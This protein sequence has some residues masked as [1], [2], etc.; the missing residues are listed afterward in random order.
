MF[1]LNIEQKLILFSHVLGKKCILP[2]SCY[3]VQAY[4]SRL[5][6]KNCENENSNE[7]IDISLDIK[8][9]VKNFTI[10]QN[11]EKS[12]VEI[13]GISS[14]GYF[15]YKIM[16]DDNK[17]N[18]TLFS[19]PKK[20]I[21]ISINGKNEKAYKKLDV[22]TFPIKIFKENVFFEKLFLGMNKNLNME[23]ISYREDL[24]EILPI[25][26]KLSQEVPEV[27]KKI[28]GT[29]NLLKDCKE[30]VENKKDIKMPFIKAYKACFY[31]IFVPR[32]I[33][34]Q[35][36]GIYDKEEKIPSDSSSLVILTYAKHIIRSMFFEKTDNTLKILPFLFKEFHSGRFLNIDCEDI[37]S[38]D[39]E[40]SKKLI[41]RMVLRAKKDTSIKLLLQPSVKNFRVRK[42]NGDRG[43]LFLKN[44]EIFIKENNVYY[45]D[46]FKK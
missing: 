3:C 8:G 39:I 9:P 15:R 21:N 23:K 19:I 37:G 22:L 4:V 18:L 24:K 16:V 11:L 17:I 29:A 33:D 45:F 31:D 38:L 27:G 41:R 10:S 5:V 12:F 7:E 6:I 32:L 30:A 36:Q 2:K 26:F 28:I 40:W 46:R 20:S 14:E 43:K 34:D 44:E 35:Y 25:W 1:K 42:N 13:S